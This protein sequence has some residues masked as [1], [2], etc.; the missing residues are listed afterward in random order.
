MIRY[1]GWVYSQ[2]RSG[3]ELYLGWARQ[4]GTGQ[5][6]DAPVREVYKHACRHFPGGPVTSSLLPR[7]GDAA[8][9]RTEL[10]HAPA[11][12]QRPTARTRG[13]QINRF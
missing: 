3:K 7:A 1:H 2:N 10:S 9:W 8:E 11:K 12:T 6:P 5:V 13:S 4:S